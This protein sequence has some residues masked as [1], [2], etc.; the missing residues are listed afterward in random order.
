MGSSEVRDTVPLF[1]VLPAASNLVA[2]SLICATH[3]NRTNTGRERPLACVGTM[4]KQI[5]SLPP[6]GSC[7]RATLRPPWL[8]TFSSPDPYQVPPS[9]I[10]RRPAPFSPA[11]SRSPLNIQ[12]LRNALRANNR[13]QIIGTVYH[14]NEKRSSCHAPSRQKRWRRL[15]VS[16]AP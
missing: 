6:T 2:A 5:G 13:W 10:I 16:I 9:S 15:G 11:A 1:S 12:T 8:F 3:N 14:Q 4:K 7:P